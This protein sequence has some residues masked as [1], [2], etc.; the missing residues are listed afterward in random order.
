MN[1]FDIQPSQLYLNWDKLDK[2]N[3]YLDSI[4]IEQ[5]EPLPIKQLD[6]QIFLLM[7]ILELM[8][9]TREVSI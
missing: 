2:V 3:K 7:D 9:F 6:N 1:V 5:I 8:L 4:N